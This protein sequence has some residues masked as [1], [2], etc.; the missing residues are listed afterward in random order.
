M[1]I[2]DLLHLGIW[3]AQECWGWGS[4]GVVLCPL[5]CSWKKVKRG[6]VLGEGADAQNRL[7]FN[8]AAPL[9]KYSDARWFIGVALKQYWWGFIPYVMELGQDNRFLWFYYVLFLFS[10]DSLNLQTSSFPRWRLKTHMLRYGPFLW[11]PL[12]HKIMGITMG[13]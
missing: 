1:P 4:W 10:F 5:W 2:T 7:S 9:Q 6:M 8:C 13:G 3:F 12:L 11:W